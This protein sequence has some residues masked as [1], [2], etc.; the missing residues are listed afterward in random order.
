MVV[1]GGGVC[2]RF[3]VDSDVQKNVFFTMFPRIFTVG[4]CERFKTSKH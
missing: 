3:I 2:L 4:R 1:G